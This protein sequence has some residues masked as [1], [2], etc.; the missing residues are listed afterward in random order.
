MYEQFIVRYTAEYEVWAKTK[1]EAIQQAIK[2][3]SDNPE[4]EFEAQ[5]IDLENS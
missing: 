4:G 5:K 3:H 2:Q 1:D